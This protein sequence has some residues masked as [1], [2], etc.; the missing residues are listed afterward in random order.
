MSGS[1]ELI[2]V[3]NNPKIK[4]NSII[5]VDDICTSLDLPRDIL[6]DN[7]S[8]TFGLQNLNR[9]LSKVPSRLKGKEL[10]KLYVAASVGLYDDAVLRIWNLVINELKNKINAYGID[11]VKLV[12]KRNNIKENYDEKSIDQIKDVNLLKLSR[13][14]NIISAEGKYKLDNCRDIRNNASLAHYTS[15][16]LSDDEMISFINTCVKYGLQDDYDTKGIDFNNLMS[17]LN[18]ESFDE[19]DAKTWAL[20]IENTFTS[21]QE[22]IW[23]I[24]FRKLTDPSTKQTIRRN[25]IKISQNLVTQGAISDNTLNE[26]VEQFYNWKEL[27]QDDKVKTAMDL[28]T[29]LNIINNLEDQEKIAVLNK[30]I[31]NLYETHNGLNNFYNEPAVAE[32][33]LDLSIKI[34]PLP[35]GI[36]NSYVITNL[37][38]FLGNSYGVSTGAQIYYEKMLKNLTPKGMEVLL[39]I[40]END[41]NFYHQI[42]ENDNKRQRYLDL[43]SAIGN[44][45]LNESQNHYRRD[46]IIKLNEI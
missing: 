28:F 31:R 44:E 21:Q 6:P 24:L 20:K 22:L 5:V 45:S 11:M 12:V 7:E 1:Q 34:N 15:M 3:I 29:R 41:S 42:F 17:A 14:L 25:S 19:E 37:Q 8:I 18:N 38:C 10:V 30:A 46:L 33:L 23:D 16:E 35:E 36:V 27:K 9:Q 39:K 43:L 32:H 2:K 26:M 4:E 13:Q 40:H